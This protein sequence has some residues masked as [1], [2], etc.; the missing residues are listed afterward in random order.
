[1]LFAFVPMSEIVIKTLQAILSKCVKPKLI[2]KMDFS[3]GI[4]KSS[5]TMIVIP[6]IV[7]TR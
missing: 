5:A 7:K 2:P 4:P 3:L 1:M 6:S